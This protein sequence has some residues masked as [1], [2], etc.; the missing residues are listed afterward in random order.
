MLCRE[1]SRASFAR[2]GQWT[3]ATGA[4]RISEPFPAVFGSDEP[5]IGSRAHRVTD[6]KADQRTN[7][8]ITQSCTLVSVRC[9]GFN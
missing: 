7:G 4:N 2:S 9:G 8:A 5:A 1:A 6:G 3:S